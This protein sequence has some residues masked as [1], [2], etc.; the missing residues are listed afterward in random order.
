MRRRHTGH[1]VG[2]F[3]FFPASVAGLVEEKRGPQPVCVGSSSPCLA[4][5][6]WL[7]A[8]ACPV[9]M[10]GAA[11][12]GR[13]VPVRAQK[14]S[15]SGSAMGGGERTRPPSPLSPLTHP[16]SLMFFE[17]AREHAER[18]CENNPQ[19]TQV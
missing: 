17:Q 10:L 11:R 5:A 15:G 12:C 19:D 18:D 16:R 7:H 8:S 1:A 13:P 2:V 14:N 6:V 3:F 4:P 9:S